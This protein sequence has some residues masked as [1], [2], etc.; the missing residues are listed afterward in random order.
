MRKTI[1]Y[2]F[3]DFTENK[4]EVLP[5]SEMTDEQF[6]HLLFEMKPLL[7]EAASELLQPR[8]EALDFLMKKV[9]N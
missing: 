7:Q 1:R 3:T 5:D 8:K 4:P 9:L 2:N 6:S